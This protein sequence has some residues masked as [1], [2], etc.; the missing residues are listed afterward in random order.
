MR[1]GVDVSVPKEFN[2]D[3]HVSTKRASVHENA[4][5]KRVHT[6]Q[7]TL[8]V[9]RGSAERGAGGGVGWGWGGAGGGEVCFSKPDLPFHHYCIFYIALS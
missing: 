5:K 9:L 8:A 4:T 7:R 1:E 3:L 2:P 6:I